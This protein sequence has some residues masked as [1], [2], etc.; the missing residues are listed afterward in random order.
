M[1]EEAEASGGEERVFDD[2][3]KCGQLWKGADI[4]CA[5]YV[6][7]ITGPEAG[8][9]PFMVLRFLQGRAGKRASRTG[10][11]DKDDAGLVGAEHALP[12]RA[13]RLG[14]GRIRVR[15]VHGADKPAWDRSH[16]VA[17][18]DASRQGSVNDAYP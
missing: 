1:T 4:G 10:R 15:G 9:L 12:G 16:F 17:A 8:R 11:V 6:D 14:C 3:W 7:N 2:Q 18:L 5:G 13:D